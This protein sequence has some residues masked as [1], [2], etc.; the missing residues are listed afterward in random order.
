MITAKEIKTGTGAALATSGPASRAN[1][2]EGR[3]RRAAT[4]A[5]PTSYPADLMTWIV[6]GSWPGIR[7]DVW[8]IPYA[9]CGNDFG[10][11]EHEPRLATTR[12]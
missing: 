9:I 11:S 6:E 1:W 10:S 5:V 3:D 7:G 2:L 8:V 12:A 4:S